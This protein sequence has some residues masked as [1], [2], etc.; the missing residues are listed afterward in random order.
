MMKAMMFQSGAPPSDWGYAIE[1]AAFLLNRIPS[2]TLQ[3]QSRYELWHQTVLEF[4]PPASFGNLMW[5][6]VFVLRKGRMDPNAKKVVFLGVSQHAKTAV[7]RCL[8][9]HKV[10][11]TRDYKVVPGIFAYLNCKQPQPVQ[12]TG[13]TTNLQKGKIDQS[14]HQA[15][16]LDRNALW[17]TLG[18]LLPNHVETGNNYSA[19][20]IYDH[21]RD[22]TFGND[23]E[24]E[25]EGEV[26]KSNLQKRCNRVG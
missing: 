18:N 22:E 24:S 8:K 3:H 15:I 14:E 16:S 1:W 11:L 13:E 6:R 19:D 17:Q 25:R 12:T 26:Y 20:Q 9:T 10:Q 4:Y 23:N 2:R 7:V 5:A 21:D